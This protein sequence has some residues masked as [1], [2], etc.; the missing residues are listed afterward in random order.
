[1]DDVDEADL[2]ALHRVGLVHDAELEALHVLGL[3]V[4]AG[5][6]PL[7]VPARDADDPVALPAL[8]LAVDDADRAPLHALRCRRRSC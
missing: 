4:E 6:E 3:V 2:D 7:E 8:E 1:M 5:L